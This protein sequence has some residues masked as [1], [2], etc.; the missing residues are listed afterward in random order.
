MLNRSS[1]VDVRDLDGRTLGGVF[2][3]CDG[4]IG[5]RLEKGMTSC[6]VQRVQILCSHDVSKVL[7]GN[8]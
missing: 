3:R 5:R 8:L 7:R 6:A 4:R 1:E 2:K